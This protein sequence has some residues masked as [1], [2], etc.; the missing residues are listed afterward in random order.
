MRR[1]VV[2]VDNVIF[3]RESFLFNEDE[4][5]LFWGIDGNRRYIM[6]WRVI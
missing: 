2:S 3:E 6:R 5:G 4:I 1:E